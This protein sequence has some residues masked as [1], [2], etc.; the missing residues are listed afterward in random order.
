MRRVLI[1]VAALAGAVL[2][3]SPLWGAERGAAQELGRVVW[4]ED[5]DGFG[6][7]S[8]IEM[9]PDGR[10]FVALSDRAVLIEGEVLRDASGVMTGVRGL[11][12]RPLV[13]RAGALF[14]YPWADSESLAL[15][16]DGAVWIGWE[17]GTRVR[18]E[19]TGTDGPRLAPPLPPGTRLPVNAGIEALAMDGQGRLWA[20]PERPPRGEESFPV[21]VWDPAETD[22]RWR[23]A[24]RLPATGGFRVTGA[25][26]GPDGRLTLIERQFDVVGFRSR[27]RRIGLDGTGVATL[28]ETSLGAH[29]NLE[30]IS[31]W[32]DDEGLRAT[33]VADDNQ[34]AWLGTE[35][36]ELRLPD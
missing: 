18:R 35:V 4:A 7:V 3:L 13:D 21:W 1:P 14:R 27:I 36:L 2:A 23:I 29:G 30:G 15:A 16:S 22:G 25:D 10:H 19:A 31:V 8:A 11:T 24:F 9:R 17:G 26:I 6:G 32:A 34:M 33:L 28:W 12:H 20:I 5:W